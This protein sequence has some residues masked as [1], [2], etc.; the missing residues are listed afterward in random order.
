MKPMFRHI[1]F[2]VFIF[3][4]SAYADEPIRIYK[5]GVLH[6]FIRSHALTNQ[7]LE[8][9]FPNW[10]NETFDVFDKVK[11]PHSIAIDLGAWIGTT[12]IWLSNHFYHVIAVEPDRE[13]LKILPKNLEASDCSNVS[14][15]HYPISD[16]GQEVI[17]GTRTNRLNDSMSYVKTIKDHE[18]DYSVKSLTFKQLI[19]DY[20]YTNDALFTKKVGFIKCDI[21]GGEE[22][23][24]EDLLYFSYNNGCK[25]YVSFHLD[26]WKKKK[27]EDFSRLFKYFTI[28][29]GVN[30]V[31]AF[32]R[33]NPF[34]SLLFE[35]IDKGTLVKNQLTA[36]VMAYNQVTYVKDMVDQLAKYTT[37]II[38][39]DNASTFPPLLSYYDRDFKYTLLR[40]KTNKGHG[41]HTDEFVEKLTGD[42]YLLTDP[43]LKFNPNLPDNFIQTLVEVSNY[44]GAY[45]TGFALCIDAEDLRTDIEFLTGQKTFWRERL[46]YPLNRDLEIYRAGIDTTFCLVNRK[47]R[48]SSN[49]CNDIRIAKDFTCIH[50]PWHTD[51]RDAFMP[52]EIEYYLKN[53]ISTHSFKSASED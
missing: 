11:D 16:L 27:I 37:D 33:Q 7:F 52:D 2:L 13:S 36:I 46:D 50:R 40:Q 32:I 8:E 26:W 31:C 5:K 45:K 44:F 34:T 1:F 53:N 20:V 38:V 17:F 47:R 35:P 4:M 14:I 30:D 39:V 15:C 28:S 49:P 22:D 12:S 19:F 6:Q 43:D 9:A 18:L 21:E 51:Y 10:E 24:L 48:V 42:L 41:V 23:I 25:V 3:A 29:P